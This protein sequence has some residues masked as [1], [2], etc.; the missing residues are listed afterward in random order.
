M[1]LI[2]LRQF[3]RDRKRNLTAWAGNQDFLRPQ[4]CCLSAQQSDGHANRG[5]TT[6]GSFN[7]A[8]SPGIP[9]DVHLRAEP[10]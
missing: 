6:N 2:V 1:D 8:Y 9:D 4:H 7:I 10:T 5:A 3:S